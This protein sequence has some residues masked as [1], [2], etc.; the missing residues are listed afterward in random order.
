MVSNSGARSADELTPMELNTLREL[1]SSERLS[2]YDAATGGNVNSALLLYNW[3]TEAAGAVMDTVGMVEVVVRNSMD[4]SLIAWAA[5]NGHSDWFDMVR[6]DDR[7]GAKALADARY[8]AT[9]NGTASE[10]H[11]KTLAETSL[12]FWRYL[13]SRRYLTS[14]WMP[15]LAAAFPFGA[16]DKKARRE[17]VDQA[18]SKL[19][20]DRNRAAHHEPIHRRD[21][22]VDYASAQSLMAWIDPVALKWL[23][24]NSALPE[25][26]GNRP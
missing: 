11:S 19:L 21:L 23:N 15:A 4:R 9:H 14:L 24:A 5:T 2:S 26:I 16:A 20:T 6:L 8:R 10:I 12:G 17:N 22:N 18:L 25:V 3:N 13:A 1:I 7:Q